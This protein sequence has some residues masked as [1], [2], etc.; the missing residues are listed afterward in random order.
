MYGALGSP[1]KFLNSSL[2]AASR[3]NFRIVHPRPKARDM[4]GHSLIGIICVALLG[5]T[6]AKGKFV[7]EA[8]LD[9][10][11]YHLWAHFHW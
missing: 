2:L 9:P 8:S 4:I 6:L 1:S 5:H 7:K 10:A 3:E 11:P